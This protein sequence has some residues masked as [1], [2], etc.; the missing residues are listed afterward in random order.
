MIS[1]QV[2][3][4]DQEVM[5][6][7]HELLIRGQ[8]LTPVM[9][10][11][12]GVL[13]DASLRAFGNESDP[14]TGTPWVPLKE[15]TTERKIGG[16]VRGDHPILQVIG[17]LRRS[18]EGSVSYGPDWAAVGSNLDYAAIHQFGGLP[19]MPPGPAAVPAR[20]Y[21]GVGDDDLE[22]ILD[23]VQGYLQGG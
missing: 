2:R 15:G 1:I 8:D 6:V 5:D 3:L 9:R 21:L 16:G 11:I 20:P 4:D 19:G 10:D 17:Q 7:L 22:E 18:V 12:A 23:L 14:A 13:K